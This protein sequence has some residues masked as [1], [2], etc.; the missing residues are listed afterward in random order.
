MTNC[1]LAERRLKF[2]RPVSPRPR[3]VSET[4]A[5]GPRFDGTPKMALLRSVLSGRGPFSWP[6]TWPPKPKPSEDLFTESVLAPRAE[7]SKQR[8]RNHFHRERLLNRRPSIDPRQS[9][10]RRGLGSVCVGICIGLV[11]R[12]RP[13]EAARLLPSRRHQTRPVSSSSQGRDAVR[14][15]VPASRVSPG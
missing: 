3:S 15:D 14:F 6:W 4:V 2:T 12:E 8:R 5:L 13:R 9:P 10:A 1:L 11:D 7:T